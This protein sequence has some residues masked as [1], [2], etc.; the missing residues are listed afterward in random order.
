MP[1]ASLEKSI[2]FYRAN[3]K[4]YGVF[5][6]LYNRSIEFEGQTFKNAEYAYQYGKSDDPKVRA[7]LMQAPNARLLAVVAHQLGAWDGVKAGWNVRKVERMRG[8]VRAKFEQHED[9]RDIL[10]STRNARL[11]EAGTVDNTVNRFWGQVN[12]RGENM[13]GRILMDV[14]A[15]LRAPK[16]KGRT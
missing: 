1:A 15:D 6:N 11:V 8:V 10:L 16:R 4:P 5:S 7:W 2:Q 3:E 12:G 14:R 13:L 9:L